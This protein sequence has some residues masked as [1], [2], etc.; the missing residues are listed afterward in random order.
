MFCLPFEKGFT[1][2]GKKFFSFKVGPFSE[3]VCCAG[4]QTGNDKSC[5]LLKKADSVPSTH[6]ENTP[7]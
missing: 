6:H 4:E 3:E 2:K 7:I 1:F 5:L